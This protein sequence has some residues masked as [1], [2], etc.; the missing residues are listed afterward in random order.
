MAS[1]IDVANK[2]AKD[3]NITLTSAKT[4]IVTVL[5]TIIDIAKTERI[6][7]GNHIFKPL[8]KKERT[9]RNPRTGESL[10]IPEKHCIKYKY[11]GDRK[12]EPVAPTA[13]KAKSKR[14]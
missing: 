5:D 8:T 13:I 9:G 2:L 14:R 7:V 12:V 4:M 1:T 10:I 3:Y 6:K 11:T